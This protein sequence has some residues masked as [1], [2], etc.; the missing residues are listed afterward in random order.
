MV[1]IVNKKL[2]S[3]VHAK[4]LNRFSVYFEKKY[5]NMLVFIYM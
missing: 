2:T 5:R 1:K 4:N 3:A